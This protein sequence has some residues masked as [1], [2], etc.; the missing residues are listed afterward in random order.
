MDS[1]IKLPASFIGSHAWTL[2]Q[3]A[4]AMALGHK[5]GKLTFFYTMTFNPD[6]SEIHECLQPELPHDNEA[7]QPEDSWVV[8]YCP[9]L[10]NFTDCHFHFNVIYTAKVFSYLY[11]YLYKGLDTAFFSVDEDQRADEPTPVNEVADY[12]KA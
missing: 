5:Y 9:A 3:T 10:L 2:E 7:L 4:D 8:P 6:W 12:Q 11:K 1:A